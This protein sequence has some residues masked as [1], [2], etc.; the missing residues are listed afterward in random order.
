MERLSSTCPPIWAPFPFGLA[1]R[2]EY[3]GPGLVLDSLLSLPS[4]RFH[5]LQQDLSGSHLQPTA[6]R[7]YPLGGRLFIMT[8]TQPVPLRA[9]SESSSRVDNPL[10]VG[11]DLWKYLALVPSLSAPARGAASSVLCWPT[12]RP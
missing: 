10:T 4:V 12:R 7:K 8:T 9:S 2:W 6:A 11:Y 3:P 5:P 1:G